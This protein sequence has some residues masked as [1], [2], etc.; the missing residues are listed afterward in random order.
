MVRMFSKA[1]A[2]LDIALLSTFAVFVAVLVN[3]PAFP[4]VAYF[5][6]LFALMIAANAI[7]IRREARIERQLD[8]LELASVSFGAR[9][10]VSAIGI[11]AM[12]FLFVTP[13]Q[14]AVLAWFQQV[15]LNVEARGGRAMSAPATVFL[16]GMMVAMAIFLTAKSALA[17]IWK[18]TKR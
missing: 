1:G 2:V 13:L 15:E 16:L 8:E 18:W 9:W 17:T 6:S 12:L 4:P 5:A 3:K 7:G 10:A 14:D 11:A